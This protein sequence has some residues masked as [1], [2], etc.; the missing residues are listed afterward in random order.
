MEKNQLFS[1]IIE[2][3]NN[4]NLDIDIKFKS[5]K[6]NYIKNMT[7]K[8]LN[9]LSIK[10]NYIMNDEDSKNRSWYGNGY[11]LGL[12]EIESQVKKLILK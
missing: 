12:F 1:N 7:N 9:N 6:E 2:Y 4:I 11:D 5:K 10:L 8:F 3:L